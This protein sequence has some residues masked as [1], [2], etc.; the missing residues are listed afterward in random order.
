MITAHVEKFTELVGKD[1]ALLAKLPKGKPTAIPCAVPAHRPR[2]DSRPV[3]H[4]FEHNPSRTPTLGTNSACA[5]LAGR[6]GTFFAITKKTRS[7]TLNM[8]I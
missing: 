5:A 8:T 3:G 6:A 1:P 7:L 4:Q 2:S